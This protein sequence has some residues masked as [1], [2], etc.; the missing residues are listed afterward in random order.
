MQRWIFE[1]P[2][3]LL[4]AIAVA[5]VALLLSGNNRQNPRLKLAGVGVLLA[6]AVLWA[7]SYFVK[8]PR[9][10]AVAGT[11]EAIAAVVAK[12]RATLD[13]L[14]HP[15]AVLMGWGR[16]DIL[17][18]ALRYADQYGLQNAYVTSIEDTDATRTNVTVVVSVLSRHDSKVAMVDT[19]PSTWQLQWMETSNGWRLRQIEPIRIMQIDRTQLPS[20]LFGR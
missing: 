3:W 20:G 17:D 10:I 6:G 13:R 18:G 5:A 1:T 16:N 14:L 11:R 15:T 4:C 8:T 2:W 7:V 19:V 12:D 9:E